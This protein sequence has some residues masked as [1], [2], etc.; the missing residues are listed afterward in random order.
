M[1]QFTIA[2]QRIQDAR[3]MVD[4]TAYFFRPKDDITPLEVAHMWNI[5]LQAAVATHSMTSWDWLEY[6][7]RK[8]LTRHFEKEQK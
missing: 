7:E 1:T 2:K 4:G 8:G 3:L 5:G 6:I